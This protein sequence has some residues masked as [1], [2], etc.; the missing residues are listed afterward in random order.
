MIVSIP[1]KYQIKTNVK[2]LLSYRSKNVSTTTRMNMDDNLN[3]EVL[4]E[5]NQQESLAIPGKIKLAENE[6]IGREKKLKS[7][8]EAWKRER[9]IKEEAYNQFLGFTKNSEVL[10]GRLAM[11]FLTTGLLTEVWTKETMIDQID[12][13]LRIVGIF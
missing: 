11:F 4:D 8:A 5:R 12:T 7:L 2:T 13:M 3:K 6:I 1:I 9:I 10:N